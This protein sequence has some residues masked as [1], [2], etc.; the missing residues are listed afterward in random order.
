MNFCFLDKGGILTYWYGPAAGAWV[1]P[2]PYDH[3]RLASGNNYSLQTKA[4]SGHSQSSGAAAG[5]AST[6]TST[7][8]S[9]AAIATRASLK[10]L[11]FSEWNNFHCDLGLWINSPSP[12]RGAKKFGKKKKKKVWKLLRMMPFS[13][14]RKLFWNWFECY[15]S[16]NGITL[17]LFHGNTSVLLQKC[18]LLYLDP[19]YSESFSS[20][21]ESG[22]LALVFACLIAA[23]LYESSINNDFTANLSPRSWTTFKV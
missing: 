23:A 2:L 1:G 12:K 7:R 20:P 8:A 22:R 4:A 15:F 5:C 21:R 13:G 3:H 6:R 9:T 10:E 19:L 14:I 11:D 16:A 18:C 17:W